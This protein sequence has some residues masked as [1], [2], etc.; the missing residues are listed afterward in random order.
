MDAAAI[1]AGTPSFTLMRAAGA[2]ATR[3]ICERYQMELGGGC[4]LLAGPGNNGGD[5][6]VVAAELKAVGV[7]VTV[8]EVEPPRTDDARLAKARY[9]GRVVGLADALA[10]AS[11]T[12]PV[13]VDGLLGTG[14]TGAPRD[15]IAS[16]IAAIDGWRAE[17]ARIVAMDAP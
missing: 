12:P 3:L 4:L 9:D 7:D 14:A 2:A 15:A 8:V 10:P 5:A 13:V 1:A 16:A 17:G 11:G 6:W